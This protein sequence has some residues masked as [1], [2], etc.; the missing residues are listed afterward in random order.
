MSIAITDPKGAPRRATPS[1]ALLRCRWDLTWGMCAVHD[2]NNSPWE[3]NTATVAN[4]GH[5]LTTGAATVAFARGTW[6][7]DTSD[8]DADVAQ[9]VECISR[10]SGVGD[11]HVNSGY[12][13]HDGHRH[14]FEL[15]AVGGEDNP[16]R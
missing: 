16:G 8:L 3:K 6:G 11:D 12:V 1:A 4:H 13:T 14:L 5:R 2:E 9:R 15:G 10:C 7:S